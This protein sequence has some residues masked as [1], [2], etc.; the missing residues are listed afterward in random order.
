MI[1]HAGLDVHFEIFNSDTQT[2]D[3]ID[4][5]FNIIIDNVILIHTIML[6]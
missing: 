1:T 5:F 3:I 2:L 6:K 4:V